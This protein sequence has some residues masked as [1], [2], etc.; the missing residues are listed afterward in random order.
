MG[1]RNFG[2][3]KSLLHFDFPYFNEPNDGLDDDVGIETWSKENSNV[4]LYGTQIPKA[5]TQAPKFGYRC[6]NPYTGGAVGTNSSSIW[7]MNSSK[8]YEIEC[9]VYGTSSGTR[10]LLRLYNSENNAILTVSITTARKITVQCPD[11]GITSSITSSAAFTASSWQHI[12]LRVSNNT[13]KVFI[14]G[15]QA[16]SQ[17]LT[18]DVT[19]SVGSV[20]LG[21]TSTQ[22]ALF[23]DEFVFRHSAGTDNP[24]V[25][26]HPYS[27]QLLLDKIGDYKGYG[28][29]ITP[30]KTINT[31]TMIN[32]YGLISSITDAKSFSVSSWSNGSII[33]TIGC[34]VMIHITTPKAKVNATLPHIGLYAFAKVDNLNGTS[35]TL[36]REISTK[37]GDDFTLSNSLLSTYYIQVISVPRYTS[38]TLNSGK[39]ITPFTYDDTNHIGGIVAFR[40]DGDCTINGS[41]LTHGKCD[42]YR[43]YRHD[44]QQGTNSKLIDRFLVCIGGGIFIS[45]GG[46]LTIP[47][48][49]R[50]GATWSGAG[51]GSNGAS[52]YGGKGSDT[53]LSSGGAG[54]V[55]G[56]GGGAVLYDDTHYANG[57][58]CGSNGISGYCGSGGGGCGGNGG[59]G[60]NTS[61]GSGGSGGGGQGNSGGSGGTGKK[62]N[63]GNAGVCGGQMDYN[64]IDGGYVGGGGG[65]G[66][67]G[68]GAWGFCKQGGGDAYTW[69]LAGAAGSDIILCCK[70]LNAVA[71]A[72]STGGGAG[73][74]KIIN[75]LGAGAGGGGT[76]FCYI[77][78]E[79]QV[80]E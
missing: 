48:T 70:K 15:I 57:G 68:C 43:L 32:S 29:V 30:A 26:T 19:L 45:C 62:T 80:S 65:G 37:N 1:K 53:K 3:I 33:P 8:D 44:Y 31:N 47:S 52:G 59:N 17:A 73:T 71:T 55:G 12:L 39:T 38:F 69:Y 64:N 54:G 7:N 79:E 34:E 58:N 67:G 72:I 35:V 77:A 76:G 36:S 4:K 2:S 21:Y 63:G 50:L 24:T 14:N 13:L 28:T 61:Y 5:G 56:G 25:P 18:P 75:S 20:N 42:G 11:W 6:L 27:G 16:L 22:S 9:F 51:D 41:I 60:T 40:V 10:H 66:A 74:T 78:C 49:A 23:I 46:K